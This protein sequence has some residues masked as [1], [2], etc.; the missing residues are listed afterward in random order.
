MR[1]YR[2]WGKRAEYEALKVGVLKILWVTLHERHMSRS[3][4][5]GNAADSPFFT[6]LYTFFATFSSASGLANGTSAACS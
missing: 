6:L 3:L 5:E 2:K 4:A 1:F